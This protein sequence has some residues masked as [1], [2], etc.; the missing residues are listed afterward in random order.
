MVVFLSKSA[1]TARPSH[2]VWPH[3]S[4][5]NLTDSYA[6]AGS[7]PG[8]PPPNSWTRPL[9][10]PSNLTDPAPQAP[11]P[12]DHQPSGIEQKDTPTACSLPYEPAGAAV[13]RRA[14]P[15]RQSSRW[16][17]PEARQAQGRHPGQR[18]SGNSARLRR[19]PLDHRSSGHPLLVR[20]EN[21]TLPAHAG[22]DRPAKGR[23][24]LRGHSCQIT[25]ELTIP[26]NET[27]SCV[28]AAH[29]REQRHILCE[30][31]EGLVA[32][33]YTAIWPG[34]TSW[35]QSRSIDVLGSAAEEDAAST[36]RFPLFDQPN[37]PTP[38]P[39]SNSSRETKDSWIQRKSPLG[40][41]TWLPYPSR[42]Y[43]CDRSASNPSLERLLRE[44]PQWRLRQSH[45]KTAIEATVAVITSRASTQGNRRVYLTRSNAL[46][47][48]AE[49]HQGR[50]SSPD[51]GTDSFLW[52]PESQHRSL[53]RHASYAVLFSCQTGTCH[54]HARAFFRRQ[55][56]AYTK[57]Y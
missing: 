33:T 22:P 12:V 28:P 18:H 26:E 51:N 47:A 45:G 23:E 5:C 7:C 21:L 48:V 1:P 17:P 38:A 24:R 30:G 36:E 35:V 42:L 11:R 34:N 52:P 41:E 31:N 55:R 9:G 53:K 50:D 15:P 25:T 27:R 40:T 4:A 6:Q 32:G 19:L 43:R 3:P 8:E 39:D 37:W 46:P 29:R 57:S 56:R 2:D 49:A 16:H 44:S 14:S 54:Y 13:L 20:L 10:D